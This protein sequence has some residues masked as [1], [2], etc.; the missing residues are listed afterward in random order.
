M[1]TPLSSKKAFTLIAIATLL[2][3]VIGAARFFR[4]QV[5]YPH[6]VVEPIENVRLEFLQEGLPKGEDCKAAAALIVGAIRG[7]CPTCR[8]AVQQCPGRL[9]PERQKLLSEEPVA[10]PISRL[11]HG[12]LAYISDNE[13]LALAACQETERRTS[14]GQGFRA[15]CYRPNTPRSL[16]SSSMWQLPDL[17]QVIFGLPSLLLFSFVFAGFLL[18]RFAAVH[19]HR[20]APT[21]GHFLPHLWT[22]F[23]SIKSFFVRRNSTLKSR[24]HVLKRSLDILIAVPL[25]LMSAPILLCAAILLLLKEGPPIF[26]VS[27]RYIGL[28]RPV[29]V[30]KFRTMVRD[31]CSPKY[32]LKE[33]FMRDG[34]LDIPLSC[35]VYTP[36]GRILERLQ[37][38]EL[39]QLINVLM[40]GMSLVGNRPLPKENLDLLARHPLWEKRFDSP[41]GIT[42]ISQ[43][44]GKLELTPIQRLHLESLY[45]RVYLEGNIIKCDLSIIWVTATCV[46]LRNMG[47]TL[48]RAEALLQQCLPGTESKAQLT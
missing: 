23:I 18:I 14:A 43:V 46:F 47:I 35:E 26:Y 24:N 7:S 11:P 9:E 4:G 2:T 3:A 36:M 5:Y 29:R 8:V 22:S 25:L 42:G 44:V 15:I 10:M 13:G 6:V 37:I 1:I 20:G 28:N 17:W 34:Y 32:G 27:T 41:A 48:E 39:P 31:A 30:V 38:V 21:Q 33:R 12:V 40:N 16:S 45:S 19:A